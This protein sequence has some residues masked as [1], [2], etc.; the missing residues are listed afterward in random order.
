M[1]PGNQQEIAAGDIF[2]AD[3]I[4]GGLRNHVI[5]VAPRYV[6]CIDVYC[7]KVSPIVD[8]KGIEP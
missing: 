5:A 1:V 3:A 2:A 6:D 7:W 4:S 8:C